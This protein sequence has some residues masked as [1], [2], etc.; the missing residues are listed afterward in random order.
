M[1]K[2]LYAHLF[3]LGRERLL[4]EHRRHD[5]VVVDVQLIVVV[6]LQVLHLHNRA[7]NDEV[8]DGHGRRRRRVVVVVQLQYVPVAIPCNAIVDLSRAQFHYAMR[9]AIAGHLM[10]AD[11]ICR[12]DCFFCVS[13][14]R[15][16]WHV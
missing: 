5:A 13:P 12:A 10:P 8:L 7:G 16:A 1:N 14:S 15:I 2:L 11:D 9:K 3:N 4:H 6:V